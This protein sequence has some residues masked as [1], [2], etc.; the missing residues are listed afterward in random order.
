MNRQR[1]L[2]V[3]ALLTPQALSHLS[4][5]EWDLLVRQGRSSNLLARLA[6][7]LTQ[8]CLINAVPL[9]PRNH[10]ISALQ[11][12]KRQEI[13]LRWEVECIT[14]ALVNADVKVVLLKGAAY[15]LAGLP[16]SHGR[17]FVDVDIM[18]P[19][20][21]LGRTES[22][23][24]IHGWQGSHHDAYDQRYYRRWMHEIPPMRHVRR[25]TTIDVHHTILP[26]TARIKVN[27]PAL[28][29]AVIALPGHS[30]LYALQP[31]DML[32]HSA[33]HLFHEGDFEKGLRDL[34]DL[35]SLF[36]HFGIAP[37]FWAQL[38]P[39]AVTLGLTR[40]LY[41]ALRYTTLMLDTSVPQYVLEAAK[42]GAPSVLVAGLMERCYMQ[43]LR[44]VHAST[45]TLGVSAARFILYIRSHWIRMPT[46]LLVY[47]L[48]RKV[49]IRPKF[50]DEE[51]SKT[52][53]DL[54][55]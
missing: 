25:G 16:A 34:F 49:F 35:D 40:P 30:N 48:G 45:S 53:T 4:A 51:N 11:M 42:I 46:F 27:T 28:L 15:V 10:L 6:H 1:D 52:A 31:V 22:E 3:T 7:E 23:L 9:S 21:G 29:E 8:N 20:S 50:H 26:E 14:R 12:A 5:L 41:Y 2:I 37:D 43:A 39:R 38:V 18:V 47:H 55:A 36:R 33:T 44:P 24:M 13:A 54:N 17:T 19:K 32:L